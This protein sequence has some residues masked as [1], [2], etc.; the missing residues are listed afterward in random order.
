MEATEQL[1]EV[2][3]ATLTEQEVLDVLSSVERGEVT[4]PEHERRDAAA[5]Y[6]GICVF[7]L[8]NGWEVAIFNDCDAWDYIEWVKTP[9]GREVDFEGLAGLGATPPPM[10]RLYDYAPPP[11]SSEALWG[12]PS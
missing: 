7:H 3:T 5:L 12:I 11:A 9:D 1:E 4:I 6:C 2:V 8:S 10:P